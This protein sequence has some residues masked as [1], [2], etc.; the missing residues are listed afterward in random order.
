[1]N[2]INFKKLAPEIESWI[3]LHAPAAATKPT[4]TKAASGADKRNV[5]TSICVTLVANATPTAGGMLVELIDGSSG[6]ATKLWT[7]RIVVPATV[8][9]GRDIT[10]SN[11]WIIGT[12]NTAMTLEATAAP[13]TN[14]QATVSMTGVII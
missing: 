9:Q 2:G 12:E 13:P 8:G 7:A 3:E 5:C 14:T 10:L 4:I 11:L 1:M 6:D